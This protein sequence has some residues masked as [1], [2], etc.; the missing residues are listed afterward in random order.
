[1]DLLILLALLVAIYVGWMIL[2]TF[3]RIER[4][5]RELHHKCGAPAPTMQSFRGD[6]VVEPSVTSKVIAGLQKA[7]LSAA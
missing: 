6:A 5:I 3:R 2:Q 4:D 1:M 7:M